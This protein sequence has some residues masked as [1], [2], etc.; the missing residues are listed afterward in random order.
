MAQ[1]VKSQSLEEVKVL[2]RSIATVALSETEGNDIHGNPIMSEV[3]KS[4]LKSKIADDTMPI[5]SEEEAEVVRLDQCT[6]IN[7]ELRRWVTDICEETKCYAEVNGDRDN[8][9]YLPELVP[10]LIRLGGYLPLWTGVMVPL[11]HSKKLTATSANAEA[12]FKNI[13]H[14]LFKHEN[15]PIRVDKFISRHLGFIEGNMRICSA[16]KIKKEAEAARKEETVKLQNPIES[17]EEQEMDE[18]CS[19]EP[20]SEETAALENWRGLAVPPKKR[21]LTSYLSP[22]P[23]WLHSDPAV[24]QKKVKLG[25]L[26]NGNQQPIRVSK[27]RYCVTNTCAFDAVCQGLCC[28][29]CDSVSA[30]NVLKGTEKNKV[31]QLVKDI[32]S[33]GVTPQTYSLRAEILSSIFSPVQL[34]SGVHHVDAQ[35]HVSTVIQN[36]MTEYPSIHFTRQCSS[37]YCKLYIPNTRKVPLISIDL[38][39]LSSSGIAHLQSA[40]EQGLHL[41]ASPCLRP[42]QSPDTCPAECKTNISEKILCMGTVCHSHRVRDLVWI[43]TDLWQF[44]ATTVEKSVTKPKQFFLS[45]FPS[46]LQLQ[47]QR[48][49]LKAIIAFQEGPTPETIGHYV[50]FCKRSPGIWEMYDDLKKEVMTPSEKISICPHAV[51]YIKE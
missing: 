11:F 10:H 48:L 51:L 42:I 35:C 36:I 1:L 7:T 32:A 38:S 6:Q 30:Q 21:K 5:S 40:V 3:S 44:W 8:M 18:N 12:E 16:K 28:A 13:K 9:H 31:F 47:D 49:T 43:D 33:K 25:L 19:Q 26:K 39:V 4:N 29:F 23:E 37:Q 15:L 34:K 17:S 14:G 20:H 27:E 41:A 24:K 46:T 2:I 50:A 22:C 45:D